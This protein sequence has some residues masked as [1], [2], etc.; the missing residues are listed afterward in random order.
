MDASGGLA[1]VDCTLRVILPP[2]P[3]VSV[4]ALPDTVNPADQPTF[5]VSLATS[6]PVQLTGQIAMTFTPDAVIPIDDGSIQFA[7]GGRTVKFTIP[8]GTST[9]MFSIPQMAFQT[10][11]VAGTITLDLSLQPSGGQTIATATRVLHINRAAPSMRN[12]ILAPTSAGFELHITGYSTPRE[13][14]RAD[15]QLS[16]SAGSNLQT[17][18]LTIPLT[19]LASN[20]YQSVASRVFGSQFTLVLPFTIQGNAAGIDSVSVSLANNTGSSQ[21]VNVKFQH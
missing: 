9:A 8:A 6:Y 21:G 5:N 1:S 3:S 14:T 18:Q 15:V 13:L 17:T 10:G 7:T 16:P 2:A 4:D 12:V 20:W 11:T 19:D